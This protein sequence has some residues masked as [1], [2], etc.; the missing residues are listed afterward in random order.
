[1]AKKPGTNVVRLA[2]AGVLEG[3]DKIFR[4]HKFV[5]GELVVCCDDNRL[6][7]LLNTF[8]GRLP[9]GAPERLD[10]AEGLAAYKA[11]CQASHTAMNLSAVHA[12]GKVQDQVDINNVNEVDDQ[13]DLDKELADLV[14]QGESN[15][16]NDSVVDEG[17]SESE[18]DPDPTVMNDAVVDPE[19]VRENELRAALGQLDHSDPEHWT[20]TGLP[21]VDVVEEKLGGDVS[22]KEL[23][24]FFPDFVRS[25]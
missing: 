5:E 14:E 3:K 21:K 1:M 22:R 18:E 20:S 8:R 13:D 11:Y 16:D 12:L 4:G 23:N 15:D 17:D 24:K 19:V 2:L 9:V 10:P 7:A 6:A 25:H